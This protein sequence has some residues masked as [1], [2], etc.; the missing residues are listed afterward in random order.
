MGLFDFIGDVVD[1]VGD[2]LNSLWGKIR[3]V[4]GTALDFAKD[5]LDSKA[6]DVLMRVSDALAMAGIPGPAVISKIVDFVR[7]ATVV[8]GATTSNLSNYVIANAQSLMGNGLVGTTAVGIDP[9]GWINQLVEGIREGVTQVAYALRNSTSMILEGATEAL[10]RTGTVIAARMSGIIGNVAGTIDRVMDATVAGVEKAVGGLVAS[11]KDVAGELREKVGASIEGIASAT[12]RVLSSVGS[13]IGELV[14][15]TSASLGKTYDAITTGVGNVLD[16]VGARF[17]STV[18]ALS[19]GVES[20]L[21]NVSS[22]T[23]RVVSGIGSGVGSLLDAARDVYSN[24]AGGVDRVLGGIRDTAGRVVSGM[25]D[26]IRAFIDALISGAASVAGRISNLMEGVGKAA[27]ELGERITEGFRENVTEPVSEAAEALVERFKAAWDKT[28]NG[29]SPESERAFSAVLRALGVPGDVAAKITSAVAGASKTQQVVGT[30]ALAFSSP[31]LIGLLAAGV[32]Q[33]VVQQIQQEVNRSVRPG[34]L[35]PPDLAD[36]VKRGIIPRAYM[37]DQLAQ[38]GYT[39]QQ[40]AYLIELSDR[41]Q[42]AGELLLFWLRGLMS[43]AELDAELRGQGTKEADIGRLKSAAFWIPPVGDLIRFAV[44]ETYT[45]STRAEYGLDQDFPEGILPPLRQQGV[46]EEYARHYWAAHWELPSLT[47][48]YEMLHRGVITEEQL[49]GLMRAQ[50]VMPAWRQ[51]LAEI[52]Y[53]PLTRV[54]VQRM[55]KLKVLTREEVVKAYKDLGYNQVNAERLADFVVA[56]DEADTSDDPKELADLG[57][58]TI[59]GLMEDGAIT[60]EQAGVALIGYGFTPDAAEILVRARLLDMQRAERKETA[61]TIVDM[62]TAGQMEG[63]RARTLLAGLGYSVME[64]SRWLTKVTREE[65]KRLQL[66]SKADLDKMFK[67]GIIDLAVYSEAMR[68]HGYEDVWIARY[69][70]LNLQALAPE[71]ETAA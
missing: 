7:K 64:L 43:E 16:T 21:G 15:S 36:G 14:S 18:S 12:D 2:L 63:D 10:D 29:T 46:S 35:G 48:G 52:S 3:K 71:P 31:I 32:A 28:I 23:S 44:R 25:G 41:I 57:R 27:R 37:A 53:S 55:Y 56:L 47:Q 39:D 67:A 65:E 45:P 4:F 24:L 33:P 69:V 22:A 62:V 54:D 61:Q 20:I 59:L 6:L 68:R 40:T 42:P 13:G 50:D 5:L 1:K 66:P 30:L 38:G 70:E 8:A 19:G 34:L 9:S 51:R 17:D 26:G 11:A 49:F 58:T 60:E